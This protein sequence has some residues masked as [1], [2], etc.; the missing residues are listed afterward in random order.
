[1]P[2]TRF[3]HSA[4]ETMGGPLGPRGEGEGPAELSLEQLL[5]RT[6]T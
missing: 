2:H 1:M 5:T 6:L 3:A 4:G